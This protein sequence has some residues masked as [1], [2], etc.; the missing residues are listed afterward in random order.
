[1]PTEV[2]VTTGIVCTVPVNR[3]AVL[4]NEMRVA[5]YRNNI[6]AFIVSLNYK[7]NIKK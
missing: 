3:Q 6:I 5:I 2:P 1:M 7:I 4:V